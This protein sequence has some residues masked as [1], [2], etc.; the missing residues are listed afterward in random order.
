MRR[1]AF[2]DERTRLSSAICSFACCAI[3]PH[4]IACLDRFEHPLFRL[5]AAGLFC[6]LSSSNAFASCGGFMRRLISTV[7][8]RGRLRQPI[9]AEEA[10]TS[11]KVKTFDRGYRHFSPSRLN[12]V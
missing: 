1:H 12:R 11:A 4:A 7:T 6:A 3:G 5:F 9:G 2:P 8:L 10:G